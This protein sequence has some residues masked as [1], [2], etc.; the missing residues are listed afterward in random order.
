MNNS[1][2]KK[3][4]ILGGGAVGSVIAAALSRN[5]GIRLSLIGRKPHIDIINKNGL[6]ISGVT[7]EISLI[8]CHDDITASLDHTLVILTTKATDLHD[9]LEGIGP[10]IRPSTLFLALQNGLGISEIILNH[11]EAVIH[12]RQL[13]RGIVGFGATFLE[14][15]SIRFWGGKLIV[16]ERFSGTP[17]HEIFAGTII[18]YHAT[19]SIDKRIWRK[20][21]VNSIYNPLSVF[22][23][24][25]NKTISGEEMNPIKRN[26]L[27]EGVAVA[28]SEGIDPEISLDQ[29]N[30]VVS[31]GNITSMFQDHLKGRKSEIEYINGAIAAIGEKN[32]IP[33]PINRFITELIR[34][35]EYIHENNLEASVLQGNR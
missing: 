24:T 16:E 17:F 1:Q 2:T 27:A 15:G 9:T 10:F 33:T 26:L 12:P 19:S 20:V 31:S 8:R 25:D 7:E 22:L 32:G 13:Y 18:Q 29:I 11:P 14:A 28:K 35:I 30:R 34:S 3:V 5:T 4:I 6:R 21:I 23:K